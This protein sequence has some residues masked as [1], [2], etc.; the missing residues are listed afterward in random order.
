MK[1]QEN[2]RLLLALSVLFFLIVIPFLKTY[3]WDQRVKGA[4][5]FPS[6]FAAAKLTF[7][8]G[9]SPY[10]EENWQLAGQYVPNEKVFAFLYPPPSLILFGFF[11]MLPYQI[12]KV[13]ML[14]LNHV[15]LF[16]SLVL[17]LR[18]VRL[19][20]DG[21][22]FA[23]FLVYLFSFHPLIETIDY[24]QVNIMILFF[25]T[26]FWFAYDRGD[27]P[28]SI[29]LPLALSI[30]LKVYTAIF[31]LYLL[32]RK[33]FRIIWWVIGI[34]LLVIILTIPILPSSAWPDWIT[35]VVLAG[36]YGST[37]R[38]VASSSAHE[39]QSLHGFFARLFTGGERIKALI[40]SAE[41]GQWIPY[42]ALALF[43]IL[44]V[45]PHFKAKDIK[46][47]RG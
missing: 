46:N 1:I 17:M 21:I 25:I 42:L 3:A 16:A 30:L 13:S 7:E 26:W 37:L 34:G 27:K 14:A 10:T 43:M 33:E 44:L 6:Y 4:L 9:L 36:G 23:A 38:G 28:I 29:A 12:A 35:G 2:K 32:L 20:L 15:L 31:I 22:I 47:D 41:L 5:D 8:D 39:N 11:S 18:V 19:K 24:G 40:P 45:F